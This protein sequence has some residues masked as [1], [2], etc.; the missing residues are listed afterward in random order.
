MKPETSHQYASLS[1][2]EK[3][4]AKQQISSLDVDYNS[5]MQQKSQIKQ[6]SRFTTSCLFTVDVFKKRYDFASDNFADI[7]GFDSSCLQHI[8]KQGDMLEDRFHPDDRAQILDVQIRHSEF[9]Y[10]LPPENRNN[11]STSYQ[12]RMLNR[13]QEYI[14]VI[15]RQRVIQT[16]RNGKAWIIMGTL[17][18]SPDQLTTN[19]IK[20]SFL[21]LKA[22]DVTYPLPTKECLTKREK[23]ILNFIRQGLLTKEI[24]NKLGLSIYT[25]NNHRKNILAKLDADNAIEAI[26]Q[27]AKLGL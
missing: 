11:Y 9:I 4:W 20:C 10:S 12:F 6:I 22:G 1:T 13:K 24:A 8:E 25:I 27:A 7:F 5:W 23:E 19:Q 2:L 3:M 21:N 18:I 14:N 15:S 16:D 26:N 17:D